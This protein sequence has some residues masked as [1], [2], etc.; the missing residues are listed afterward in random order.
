MAI[1]VGWVP[2]AVRQ[3]A[4]FEENYAKL[5]AVLGER[6]PSRDEILEAARV[7]PSRTA[8]QVVL[9]WRVHWRAPKPRPVVG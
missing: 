9:Y 8:L 7:D 2:D 6:C 5:H 4:V 1:H 3:A